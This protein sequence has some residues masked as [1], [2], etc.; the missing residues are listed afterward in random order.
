M[1]VPAM[2]PWVIDGVVQRRA[3]IVNFLDLVFN[4][5]TVQRLS[6]V[7]LGCFAVGAFFVLSVSAYFVLKASTGN[8]P[9]IRSTA[10][11]FWV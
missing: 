2:V 4:P 3:E 6:H 11:W 1:A 5:S 10:L 7:L 8:L 9:A